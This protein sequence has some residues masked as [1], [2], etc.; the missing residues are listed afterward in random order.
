MFSNLCS[1]CLSAD[2]YTKYMIYSEMR[3]LVYRLFLLIRVTMI[4]DKGAK[5]V[6]RALSLEDAVENAHSE[7][8]A[9]PAF[10]NLTNIPS[11]YWNQNQSYQ[12]LPL[13]QPYHHWQIVP[14]KYLVQDSTA[15]KSNIIL[16]EMSPHT[17]LLLQTFRI[18]Q[19][20]V[21]F[22]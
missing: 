5:L 11:Q 18:S 12:S 14:T 6:E 21:A 22:T 20:S 1:A 7:R 17:C 13:G 8:R 16:Q 15:S 4:F 2:Y 3:A 19:K 10:G 9:A